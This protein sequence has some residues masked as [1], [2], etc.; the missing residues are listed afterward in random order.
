MLRAAD[1]GDIA[2]LNEWQI[3]LSDELCR[4]ANLVLAMLDGMP[5]REAAERCGVNIKTAYKWRTRWNRG[6]AKGLETKHWRMNRNSEQFIKISLRRQIEQ[7]DD[8]N[9]SHVELKRLVLQ[10]ARDQPRD[11]PK[12]ASNTHARTKLGCLQLL[13]NIVKAE[14]SGRGGKKSLA[15]LMG[16]D[17]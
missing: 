11:D 15:E 13:H 1:V 3:G 14:S 9:I 6:G 17:L 5:V 16:E 10:L 4:R 8:P 12:G 7:L 2:T